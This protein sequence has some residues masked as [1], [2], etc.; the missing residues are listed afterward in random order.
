LSAVRP[1]NLSRK[2]LFREDDGEHHVGREDA[3]RH[4]ARCEPFLRRRQALPCPRSPDRVATCP[5]A[6]C[7]ASTIFVRLGKTLL[8]ANLRTI[9]SRKS[10]D[11]I[12]GLVGDG[13]PDRQLSLRSGHMMSFGAGLSVPAVK[14]ASSRHQRFRSV[15]AG[16]PRAFTQLCVSAR[17]AACH[18]GTGADGG[19]PAWRD[20]WSGE[21][22]RTRGAVVSHAVSKRCLETL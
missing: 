22:R 3:L 2:I 5:P 19:T 9:S 18:P 8:S 15:S 16:R 13:P 7:P 21:E 17:M 4:V 14:C 20:T 11:V 6:E 12:A 10:N 1:T